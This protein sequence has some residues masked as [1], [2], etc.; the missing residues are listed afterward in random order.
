MPIK[1]AQGTA[2]VF[3]FFPLKAYS[4]RILL[5]KTRLF[6]QGIN[7]GST[8]NEPSFGRRLIPTLID[9]TANANPH[10]IYCFLPKGTAVEHGFES[11]TYYMFA[12][13]INRCSQWMEAELGRGQNFNTLAYLGPSDLLTTI[14][15]V[16]AIKTGHKV[17]DWR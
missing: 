6:F 14:I 4:L 10:G 16:A 3:T 11:V 17:C 5:R 13:A 7:M 2:D 9:E 12:D 15:I 1:D 8:A